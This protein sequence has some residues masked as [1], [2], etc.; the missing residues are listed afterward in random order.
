[1][2]FVRRFTTIGALVTIV[3]IGLFLVLR[4]VV[5]WPVIVADV[6]AITVAA[7]ASYW[8][9]RAITYAAEPARRWYRDVRHYVAA[10][11]F[12]G[13]VDLAVLLV[14][15]GNSTAVLHL[16]IA[17]LAA[18]V[19]A[20]LIRLVSYRQTMFDV[21]RSDQ[22]RDPERGPAPGEVRLSLVI[23]AYCEEAGIAAT[24]DRV[25]QALG[26]LRDEGGFEL[27]V[28]D[29]GSPDD[30]SSAARD[31]GADVVITLE[32][33][34][35]KG[36]A[37]R[38][39]MLAA[40]GRSV[41][42]TDADLSYSPDQV[43]RLLAALEEGWDVVVG[44]RKH[45]STLTLVETGRLREIGSRVVNA[46]TMFVLLGQYRDTQ[47]G[48]KAFRSDVARLVFSR[49][50]IDGFAFDIEVFHLCERFRLTLTEVPVEVA[51]SERSTVHVARDTIRLIRDVFRIRSIAHTGGYEIEP[52]EPTDFVTAN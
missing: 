35:G 1:M 51:N 39:G 22:G 8:L 50:R 41:A 23:P 3:D 28:V 40:R 7:V 12:A 33:N 18:V 5:G 52:D 48:L 6:I 9:H 30:T 25:E 42:F 19:V 49:T 44:S 24:V 14:V 26:H 43:L 34:Q 29:D 45:T 20:F 37:V 46:L 32:R 4:S 2:R 15:A 36:A 10:A 38:A 47:C 11:T 16:L 27:I 17:K 31:A 13:L 21:I